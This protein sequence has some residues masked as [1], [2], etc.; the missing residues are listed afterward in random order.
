MVNETL[1]RY[2]DWTYGAAVTVY[3]FAMIFALIE[4]GLTRPRRQVKAE[5]RQLATVGGP[6]VTE[7]PAP[8]LVHAGLVK[9]GRAD[10]IGRMAAAL[11]ILGSMLHF[12]SIVLRGFAT[13]RAP[14]GNMY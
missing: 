10:P 13:G 11:L 1:A 5:A 2:S 4:L 8:P 12:T 7:T 14:W 9:R 6:A 3:I